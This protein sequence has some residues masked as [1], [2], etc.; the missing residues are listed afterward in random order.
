[1]VEVSE[2]ARRTGVSKEMLQELQKKGRERAR[3]LRIQVQ[4]VQIVVQL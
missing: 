3:E 4:L 2:G 1:M